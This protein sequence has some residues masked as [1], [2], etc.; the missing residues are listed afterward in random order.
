MERVRAFAVC[1]CRSA[2]SICVK[3]TG[4][5]RKTR[6]IGRNR[7][8]QINWLSYRL[9]CSRYPFENPHPAFLRPFAHKLSNTLQHTL[10]LRLASGRS[11]MHA[12]MLQVEFNIKLSMAGFLPT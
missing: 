8:L 5:H 11:C 9:Q 4:L 7:R 12:S 2:N 6:C 3:S 1:D 10:W